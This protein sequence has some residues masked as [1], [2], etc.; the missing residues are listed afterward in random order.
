MFKFLPTAFAVLFVFNLHAQQAG[1][2]MIKV[3]GKVM[4]KKDSS[5]ISSSI[6]YEK[7]P[8]YDDMGMGRTGDDGSFEFYLVKDTKY[9][10][11]VKKA[12]YDP[13]KTEELITDDDGDGVANLEFYL[14]PGEELELITLHN[15]IFARGSDRISESSFKELDDLVVWMDSRPSMI[16]QLEGHTDFTGNAEANMKLSQAR[17]DAVKEYLLGKGIKKNRV[18]TKAFGGTQPLSTERTDEAKTMNRRVEAR[19]VSK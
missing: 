4:S 18:L 13:S 10:F 11:T 12:D 3:V 15:L 6:L 1:D 7:L 14:N 8:Y 2:T 9:S 19:V 5:T 16:I 17:V